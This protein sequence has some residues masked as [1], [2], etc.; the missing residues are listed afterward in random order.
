MRRLQI[1]FGRLPGIWFAHHLQGAVSSLS[2]LRGTPLP[3]LMTVLVIG[4]ALALPGALFVLTRN[5]E[6]LGDGW[7]QTAAIS[8]FLKAGVSEAKAK[9]LARRLEG[10]PDL[11]SVTLISPD[12]ALEELRAE[13]GFAEAVEQLET[14]PLPYVLA[15]RP[16]QSLGDAASL[17]GL[18]EVLTALPETDLVRM[19]TLWVRRFQGI[20]LLGERAAQVLAFTLAL[21][22][23]LVIGNTIR[24]EIENRRQEIVIM[25]TVGATHA[26]I[27]RPFL[28]LGVWHG[29]LGG[30]IAWFLVSLALLFMQGPVSR[31]AAL[32]QADFV[33][34]GLGPGAL[35]FL[36]GGSLLLGLAGS[37]ISVSRHL[38]AIEAV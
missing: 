5:L 14:N 38:A 34:V 16:A 10:R 30:C 35:A 3:T 7:E 27:R 1:P 4:I 18:R 33:L 15:L 28:W 2:R 37:W 6:R 23:L 32:Y 21:G 13:T 31:L 9:A 19:D 26:F 36:L 24:L 8:L 12:Q 20:V 22:V 17:E 11:E 25:E 29:V